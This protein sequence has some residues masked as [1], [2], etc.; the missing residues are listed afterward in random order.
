MLLKNEGNVLAQESIGAVYIV[1]GALNIEIELVSVAG[2]RSFKTYQ[3]MQHG[4]GGALNSLL[5]YLICDSIRLS[6]H[7]ASPYL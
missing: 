3:Y 2:E 6:K 4:S 7:K 1:S 5:L